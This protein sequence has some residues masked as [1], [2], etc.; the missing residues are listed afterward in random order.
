MAVNF[1]SILN[2]QLDEVKRPPNV[3]VGTYRVKVTKVPEVAETAD[4]NWQTI[5]FRLALLEALENVDTEALE[6]FGGLGANPAANVR[7]Q[8]MFNIKDDTAEATANNDRTSFRLKT[9]L[10]DHLRL[11]EGGTLNEAMAAAPGNECLA[12]VQWRTDKNDPEIQYAEVRK[13][14][15][16]I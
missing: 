7:H 11:S 12:T 8:F 3:P 14:A 4:G 16:I 1:S 2:R 6:Q 10:I 9:F 15:P 13:T 5:S